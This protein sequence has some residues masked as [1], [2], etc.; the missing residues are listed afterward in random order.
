MTRGTSFLNFEEGIPFLF[1][2]VE[3]DVLCRY[4]DPEYFRTNQ[5]TVSSDI[6][7]FGMVLLEIITGQPVIDPKRGEATNLQD[8]VR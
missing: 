4:V 3:F 7:S 8:W 5:V 6:F 2:G 1:F